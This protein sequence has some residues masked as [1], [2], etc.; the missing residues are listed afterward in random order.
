MA[1]VVLCSFSSLRAQENQRLDSLEREFKHRIGTEKSRILY[2]LVYDYLRIDIDKAKQYNE[3]AK[4]LVKTEV[5]PGSLA[6]LYMA[7]GIYLSRTGQ[8]DSAIFELNKAKELAVSTNASYALVRIYASLGHAYVSS[9]RPQD[10]LENMYAGLRVLDNQADKEV[11]LKLKTNIAWAYLELKQYR[12]C[13]DY[14]LANLS[15]ME[16]TSY[17][18][19]ALYTYNNIAISYG[20]LGMLDSARFYIDKGIA[21][22]ER[23]NDSQSLANGYFILGTIFAD[24]GKYDL[25]IEQY[26]KAR[27]Y[28]EKVGNPFFIVSDLYAMSELYF[29]LGQFQKGIAS[30]HEALALAEK[31]DLT[32]KFEGAYHSLAQNYEGLHDYVN[33]SKYY[34]L[35]AVAKDSVYEN[36][37]TQA[38]AEMR[39]RFETDKKEQQLVLQQSQLLQQQTA[40]ELTFAI[41]GVLLLS[42]ALI[43]VISILLRNR[44]KREKEV[45]LREAQTQAT[46]QSQ[47]NERRRFAQD[48][49]DG[50]GQLISALRLAIHSI[51][52]NSPL[53]ERLAIVNKAEVLLNE[54]HQEIRSIAFNLMPQTLVQSG[55]VPA[56]REMANRLN[57]SGKVTVRVS[58]FDIPERLQ[59]IQ[60]ISLYRIIQE[61]LNNI[62]KYSNA[63]VVEIQLVGHVEEIALT[64]EDNGFGFDVSILESAKGN[65]WKNIRSRLNL[66]R[67]RIDLDSRPDRKGTTL[68][69]TIP[70]ALAK[71]S[72][73]DAVVINTQ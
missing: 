17:E 28:R 25:A 53:D 9:G 1:M 39:T 61:W 56:L 29:K 59:E 40:L 6:Y 4:S 47:E 14:G 63:T 55:L 32:L 62:I 11:E 67:G 65:G 38:I 42:L 58:G 69:I 41:I 54:M 13:I 16:G 21:A 35:W 72:P 46:I 8:L 27:P 66:A 24:A 43:I 37:N 68:I 36:S 52:N 44:L 10:G 20:A 31:F 57:D 26:L 73:D 23:S 70:K 19:I 60:E 50:M 22:A 3:K 2:E 64:I 51:H 33:A 71:P 12:N 45:F 18:W 34:K 48:L 15:A 30:G 49:H 7:R 5:L